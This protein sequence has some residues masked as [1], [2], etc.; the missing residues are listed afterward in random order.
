[1]KKLTV[2]IVFGGYGSGKTRLL[3]QIASALPSQVRAAAL[4]H[5]TGPVNLD[6]L[7]YP[8]LPV[9]A[10]DP[11]CACEVEGD[12]LTCLTLFRERA[13]SVAL[14]ELAGD[15]EAEP[16]AR[17]AAGLKGVEVMVVEA[18]TEKPRE[19]LLERILGEGI[20]HKHKH[21]HK[22]E[23]GEVCGNDCGCGHGHG[24]GHGDPGCTCAERRREPQWMPFGF[25]EGTDEEALIEALGRLPEAVLRGK[26]IVGLGE[27]SWL[28]V[29][30]AG[31][32][33][34][35]RI[36]GAEDLPELY[37]VESLAV[38]DSLESVPPGGRGLLLLWTQAASEVDSVALEWE[39]ARIL[40]PCLAVDWAPEEAASFVA[41][42]MESEELVF[43]ALTAARSAAVA[44]PH[45]A[46]H[47]EILAKCYH[48]LGE[49]ERA[50]VLLREAARRDPHHLSSRLNSARLHLAYDEIDRARSLAEAVVVDYPQDPDIRAVL[51]E[52][53]LLQGEGDRAVEH[54]EAAAKG[55]PEDEVL[56]S[57]VCNLFAE[58][59]D[60]QR[61]L[62]YN[63]R[64]LCVDP[65]DDGALY[66]RGELLL[67]LDRAE[68][69]VEPLDQALA[70]GNESP[71]VMTALGIAQLRCGNDEE[72][73]GCFGDAFVLATEQLAQLPDDSASVDLLL[74]ASFRGR[75][76]QV[77]ELWER[78][79]DLEP[80]EL[81]K[82]R[83]TLSQAPDCGEAQRTLKAIERILLTAP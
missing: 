35:R 47:V 75:L 70:A 78:L 71:W 29:D 23:P 50:M 13:F 55:L 62:E 22:H 79:G 68:D 8:G 6:P 7:W 56:L 18:G 65:D 58:R 76:D 26:G 20:E 46:D 30:R 53:L 63:T 1:M 36:L 74:A 33:V 57:M 40:E 9:V 39:V 42:S 32:V 49:T 10:M 60:Y 43:E 52:A 59:G 17:A 72:A 15:Q 31:G 38:E 19:E 51:G 80:R 82:A 44:E 73:A 11:E 54:L 28:R 4:V 27:G 45:V 5:Q 12:F 66:L 69:A 48:E 14:V 21:E 34:N 3:S 16:F 41:E 61:A 25:A 67:R 64:V 81:E 37:D 83:D 77:P 24:H 2:V